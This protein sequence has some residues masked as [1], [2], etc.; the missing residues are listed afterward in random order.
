MKS[1][2]VSIITFCVAVIAIASTVVMLGVVCRALA[3]LFDLGWTA[4][5]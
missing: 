1:I 3:I 2:V 5:E 4:V